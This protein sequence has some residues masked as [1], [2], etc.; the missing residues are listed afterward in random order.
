MVRMEDG[1]IEVRPIA[2]TRMRGQTEA[3]NK[4]PAQELPAD[5]KERAGVDALD[6]LLAYFPSATVS[7][8]PKIRAMEIVDEQDLHE[9]PL[10][11]HS[12]PMAYPN[13]ATIFL[14]SITNGWKISA[15]SLCLAHNLQVCGNCST[16][17]KA[18]IVIVTQG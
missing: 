15:R 11:R 3:E 1:T 5:E 4:R 13:T 16:T 7:G 12:V 18:N 8:A 9:I 2:G 10:R 6:G 17:T 14:A